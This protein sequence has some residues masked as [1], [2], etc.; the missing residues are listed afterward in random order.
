ML[1]R[2][3]DF[4]AT[5]ALANTH[6]VESGDG[7]QIA[8]RTEGDGPALVFVNGFTTSNSYWRYMVGRFRGRATLINWDLK[9]HGNSEPAAT[10]EGAT[11]EAAVDDLRRV[12]DAAGVERATLMGFSLGAQITVEAWRQ[13]SDRIDG[14]VPI[15]GPFEHTFDSAL[16]PI[17][18]PLFWNLFEKY[19]PNAADAL[20]S[21]AYLASK[22]P[23][24]WALAKALGH[25]GEQVDFEDM[26]P[27][28]EHL[29]QVHGPT[30]AK[31]GISAHN[32]SAADVLPTV[33]V[34]MLIVSGGRDPLA[35]AELGHRMTELA[36]DAELRIVPEAT[37]TG[38]LGEREQIEAWCEEFL[39]QHELLA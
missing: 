31:L 18:G 1:K 16:P 29:A 2:T 25:V 19:G 20:L 21:S 30:W 10:D 35:P 32:H 33:D 11:I 39:E 8:Y 28:F 27:F 24:T 15:L 4:D 37:H 36:P 17:I 26:E 7:T 13:M 34:P 3:P 14:L 6:Y 9:G 38:L 5:V 23:T 12:M 22:L